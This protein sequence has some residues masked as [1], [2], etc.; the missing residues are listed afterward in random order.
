MSQRRAYSFPY[1]M[2][3]VWAQNGGLPHDPVP[4]GLAVMLAWKF[5]IFCPCRVVRIKLSNG[6]KCGLLPKQIPSGICDK[7]VNI[8]NYQEHG[9]IKAYCTL[10]S[11]S[12][13]SSEKNKKDSSVMLCSNCWEEHTTNWWGILK[14]DF[15]QY[16]ILYQPLYKP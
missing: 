6:N 15:I 10:I 9:H 16:G 13:V 7:V 12:V 2:G 14:T 3:G 1:G 4:H 5:L 8:K 11:I